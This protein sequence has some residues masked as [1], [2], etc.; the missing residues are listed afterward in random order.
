MISLRYMMLTLM[1][2]IIA[3]TAHA[4]DTDDDASGSREMRTMPAVPDEGAGTVLIST[5]DYRIGPS[6]QLE[7]DIFQIEELS[8]VERVNS[9]GYI[10]CH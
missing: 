7:I 8:G 2:A 1:L 9:R 5:T 3:V 6:D 4:A 10:R